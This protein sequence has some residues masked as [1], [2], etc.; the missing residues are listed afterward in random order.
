MLQIFKMIK[1]KE[2]YK[3]LTYRI[4]A[5]SKTIEEEKEINFNKEIIKRHQDQLNELLEIQRVD[6]E[7]RAKQEE[8]FKKN[9]IGSPTIKDLNTS[10]G[11][12]NQ[13]KEGIILNIN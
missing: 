11:L 12:I 9:S 6:K 10:N 7:K 13:E 1:S 2:T 4:K 8:S 5:L 3:S